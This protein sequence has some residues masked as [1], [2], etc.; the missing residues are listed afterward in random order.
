MTI[1]FTSIVFSFVA[2]FCAGVAP[3]T[4]FAKATLVTLPAL[5]RESQLIVYGHLSIG[6][7]SSNWL[8]L[9]V[10]DVLKGASLVRE[11]T[12]PL[13]NSRPNTEWPDLSKLTGPAVFF[14]LHSRKQNCFILSHNYRSLIKVSGNE[15][16]TLVIEGEPA[17]QTLDQFLHKIRDL[18]SEA[19]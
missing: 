13:C 12:V 2:A 3:M 7:E 18:V 8:Q 10:S 5:T 16:D 9:G 11:S 19:K 6:S 15:A 4:G 17:K 1:R 14:L